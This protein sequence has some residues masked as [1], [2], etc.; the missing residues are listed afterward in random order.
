MEHSR[1]A[2]L[3]K[4]MA[5]YSEGKHDLVLCITC[6]NV[7]VRLGRCWEQNLNSFFND[8]QRHLRL[9]VLIAIMMP[10]AG[11]IR[12]VLI[13]VTMPQYSDAVSDDPPVCAIHNE[14]HIAGYEV[15]CADKCDIT[16]PYLTLP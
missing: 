1:L 12:Y 10:R 8:V 6:R 13:A 15:R 11:K 3:S 14:L 9:Y 2:W 4:P 5:R 7:K 16:S